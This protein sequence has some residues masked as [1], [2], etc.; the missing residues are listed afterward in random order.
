MNEM[1]KVPATDEGLQCIQELIYSGINVNVTLIFSIQSYI[2]VADAYIR[3]LERRA[4]EGKSVDDIS[5]VASFFV[6]R[7]DTAIDK[8][9]KDRIRITTDE[10]EKKELQSLLGKAAIAN[11]KIAYVKFKE[12]FYG[13]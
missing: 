11:A 2:N 9:L 8:M 10:A 3:G 12:I 5:S 4:A 6:S 1:S 7:I 13:D